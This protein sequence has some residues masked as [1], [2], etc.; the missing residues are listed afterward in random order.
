MLSK[1]LSPA[2]LFVGLVLIVIAT[3]LY[4]GGSNINPNSVGFS[5]Q[6]NFISNLFDEKALNG[7]MNGGRYWAMAG[8]L[9]ISI[10]YGLFFY[11]FSKRLPSASA[12][13]VVKYVGLLGVISTFLISTPLHD[14]MVSVSSTLVLL[15]LFYIT[16]FVYKSKLHFFKIACTAHMLL[17]Y[18]T[19]FFYGAGI[20]IPYLAII[21]KLL[22]A[23][24]ILVVLG[25]HFFTKK[26]DFSL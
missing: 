13:K 3:I 10:G 20:F 7:Q 24:T 12:A 23:A 21:Q 17:F 6:H 14:I 25:L 26:E 16:V 5:W 22:F 1:P 2:S 4:P 11:S 9:F 8:M 15:C 19:M 18:A